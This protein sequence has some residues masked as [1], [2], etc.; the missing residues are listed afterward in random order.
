MASNFLEGGPHS[1]MPVDI[2]EFEGLEEQAVGGIAGVRD[3]VHLGEAG[4]GD[5]GVIE[6]VEVPDRSF[7]V[8]V[9]WHP[10]AG[11]PRSSGCSARTRARRRLPPR[12]PLA[13]GCI[14]G[15]GGI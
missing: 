3:Q 15:T 13:W 9:Q 4:E 10:C 2:G 14:K 7:V 6:A 11:I 12:D 5:G 1:E 8:G